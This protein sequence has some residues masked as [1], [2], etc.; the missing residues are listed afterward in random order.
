MLFLTHIRNT[1]LSVL[2]N[3]RQNALKENKSIQ[4]LCVC[5]FIFLI[6]NKEEVGTQFPL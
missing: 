1:K 3:V 2:P 5:V 4:E 6:Y